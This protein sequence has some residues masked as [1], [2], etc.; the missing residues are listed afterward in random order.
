MSASD[1][2]V[3][4]KCPKRFIIWH[5]VRKDVLGSLLEP[6]LT[7]TPAVHISYLLQ[8]LQSCQCDG[9]ALMELLRDP[10]G[11]MVS[12]CGTY[13]NVRTSL[14]I[15]VKCSGP[16]GQ[17]RWCPAAA[18]HQCIKKSCA[19]CTPQLRCCSFP[20]IAGPYAAAGA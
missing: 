16:L 7:E 3:F 1:T 10:I 11:C 20:A 14:S 19:K 17:R 6:G 12:K 8:S 9:F 2:T 5:R 15:S 18:P 4:H 13:H